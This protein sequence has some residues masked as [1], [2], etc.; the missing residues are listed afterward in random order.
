MIPPNPSELLMSGK[1]RDLFNEVKNDYDF[2]IIDTAPVNLV[3]DT[4][5]IAKYSDMTLYVTRANHL[6]KSMLSVPQTLYKEQKLPNMAMLLNDTD[7][8]KGY[9]YGYGYGDVYG[10]DVVKKPWYKRILK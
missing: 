8:K 10:G 2:I 6:D 1:V 9:G 4:L 3:T 5:L 7:I